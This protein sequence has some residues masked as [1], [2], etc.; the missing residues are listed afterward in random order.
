M[1]LISEFK[2]FPQRKH[3]VQMVL[4]VKSIKYLRGKI[5]LVLYKIF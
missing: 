1:K 2:A 4:L 3:M 5:I